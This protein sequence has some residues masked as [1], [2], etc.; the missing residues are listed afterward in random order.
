M[1]PVQNRSGSRTPALA[2]IP[3]RPGQPSV[4][5]PSARCRRCTPTASRFFLIK[6][7]DVCHGL[8]DTAENLAAAGFRFDIANPHL[9]P[10]FSVLAAPYE[11]GIHGNRD[12]RRRCRGPD[13]GTV[14]KRR[15]SLQGMAAQ[16]PGVDAGV[17]RKHVPQQISAHPV[18]H[19]SGQ[20]CPEPVQFRCRAAMR[21]PIDACLD[22]AARGT[23]EPR[24]PQCHLSE[25]R[26]DRVVHDNLSPGRN[27]IAA[28]ANRGPPDRVLPR[29][30]GGRSRVLNPREQ[31]FRFREGQSQIGDI[32]EVIRLADLHNVHAGTLVPGCRQLQN[33]LHAPPRGPRTGAKISGTHWHPQFCNSPLVDISPVARSSAPAG[34]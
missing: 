16:G 8:R 26:R 27:P 6:P 19:Q 12:R 18:R 29:L 2:R 14:S 10:T 22:A 15:A 11:G 25:Q 17:D 33:P 7:F 4:S 23:P 34:C 13:R 28:G 9:K 5:R 31:L 3:R 30:R 21:R 24:Q 32:A 20:V 1:E